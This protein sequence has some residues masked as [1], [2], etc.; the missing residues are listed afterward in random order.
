MAA[1]R[2]HHYTQQRA[3]T[4]VHVRGIPDVRSSV[5]GQCTTIFNRARLLRVP[6]SRWLLTVALRHT[7]G[8]K[9]QRQEARQLFAQKLT[10]RKWI[11][12][13]IDTLRRDQDSKAGKGRAEQLRATVAKLRPSAHA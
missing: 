11:A 12:S 5:A 13:C 2:A 6:A 4:Q 1:K 3:I 7:C 9:Y 10:S 8:A